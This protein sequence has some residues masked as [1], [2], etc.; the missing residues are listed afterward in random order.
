[1]LSDRSNKTAN[2]K[3]TEKEEMNNNDKNYTKLNT[4]PIPK[5]DMNYHFKD[6]EEENR[7][8][9]GFSFKND[10]LNKNAYDFLKTKDEGLAVMVLDDSIS[11]KN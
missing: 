11:T 8:T 4:T 2:F 3:T 5:F 7:E 10:L 6:E 1:M 9:S